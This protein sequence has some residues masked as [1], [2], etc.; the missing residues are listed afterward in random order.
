[1]GNLEE[2]AQ[3]VAENLQMLSPIAS[4]DRQAIASGTQVVTTT[5]HEQI[6]RDKGLLL[7]PF[8]DIG[9]LLVGRPSDI[10][11]HW[12]VNWDERFA[13]ETNTAANRGLIDEIRGSEGNF[14]C[15]VCNAPLMGSLC[16][17][18]TSEQSDNYQSDMI[19]RYTSKVLDYWKSL[20]F[21]WML[22]RR[23]S[24]DFQRATVIFTLIHR[25][26]WLIRRE[27]IL[28]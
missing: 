13:Y 20:S 2:Y 8:N 11:R 16:P 27:C 22:L 10:P 18:M 24:F 19:C 17:C 26:P 28:D 15:Y 23:L 14:S 3:E 5:V 21:H 9:S 6:D 1:M 12:I 25:I 7:R 4:S